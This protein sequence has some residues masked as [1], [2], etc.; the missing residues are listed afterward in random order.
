[1]GTSVRTHASLSHTHICWSQ[2]LSPRAVPA[3]L[4]AA[5]L[6]AFALATDARADSFTVSNTADSGLGS[7]RQ[8]ISDANA[9]QVT[10]GTACAPHSIVFAIPGNGPHRI[11]PLAPLPRF[12]IPIALDGYTQPG[13]SLNT[14]NQGTNAVITIE[15]DG[16]LAGATDAIVIGASLPTSPLCSGTGSVIR[17]LVINRFAG[18]ALSMGEEACPLNGACP[19]GSVRIQGNFFG[20]DV[21]GTVGLGNGVALG[22]S[23]LV[24]GRGSVGNIVGDQIAAD[25]GPSDPLDQTR[26]LIAASGGDGIYIGS[27]RSDA[28]SESHRV[29]NNIIG[30]SASGTTALPNAG[31]GITVDLNSTNIAIHDNLISANLGD[32]VAVFD[33]APTGSSLVANGIGIG[34]GGLAFGNGGHGVRVAGNSIGV[35]L[36]RRYRFA[37]FG[38]ASITNNL[39]AG[40]FVENLAQVDVVNGSIAANGGPAIDLAPLGV[41]PNDSGDGDGGPNELLNKPVLQAATFNPST[42]VTT[43]TGALTAAP[44]SSY[45]VHFYLNSSCDAGGFG[46][47]QSFFQLSPAPIVLNLTTDALGDATFSRQ[48]SGLGAGMSLTAL[49]RRFA[50]APGMPALIVSEFSNCVPIAAVEDLIFRNGFE[51]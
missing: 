7:L 22:R 11:Q 9:L 8:A 44:N 6:L 17:G 33:S 23:N 21:S 35:F 2:P 34:L 43:I 15:L 3:L 41:T 27:P 38:T 25:G 42:L 47:G 48:T 10:G 31:R 32:G 51:P 13:S 5:T 18:A 46:G 29:R 4:C 24:F 1:M 20:T 37:A 28:R 36:G 45:E 12:N 26:N 39:G 16:S 40:L 50:T 19:V 49:T 14:L 30:L